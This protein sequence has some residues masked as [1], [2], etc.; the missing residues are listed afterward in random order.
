[1]TKLSSTSIPK[2]IFNF[3]QESYQSENCHQMILQKKSF[4]HHIQY[5]PKEKIKTLNFVS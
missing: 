2:S 3:F 4:H 5:L 1:M